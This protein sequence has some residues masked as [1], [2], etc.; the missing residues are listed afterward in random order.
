MYAIVVSN[1]GT[2]KKGV[3]V[4]FEGGEGG[5]KSTQIERLAAYLTSKGY[6]QNNFPVSLLRG[7]IGK[8]SSTSRKVTTNLS[9][10]TT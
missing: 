8:W 5:G 7:T 3:F 1:G 4:D 10:S 9:F 2:M 6:D